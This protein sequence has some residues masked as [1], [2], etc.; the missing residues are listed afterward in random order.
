[1]C[2]SSSPLP[3]ISIP[4][5]TLPEAVALAGKKTRRGD[6]SADLLPLETLYALPPPAL[7]RKIRERTKGADR[8]IGGRERNIGLNR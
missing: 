7:R 5:T 3:S 8:W 2:S 6:R 4:S 1:M